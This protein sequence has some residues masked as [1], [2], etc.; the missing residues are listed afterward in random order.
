MNNNRRNAC[1]VRRWG[2]GFGLASAG[3]VAAAMMGVATAHA[4]DADELVSQAVSDLAHANQVLDQVPVTS[5]DPLQAAIFDEQETIQTG[6][7]ADLLNTA[8]TFQDGLPAADQTSPLLLDVDHQLVQAYSGLLDADQGFLTAD[9][10]GDLSGPGASV[11]L[12]DLS[13]IDANLVTL[14]ADFNVSA[15]DFFASF[16]PGILTA[17]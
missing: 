11:F 1:R 9:Q 7:A 16:D 6:P 14:G 12:P 17:F 4:D 2:T 10:A 8:Q 3:V 13:L 15:T 5:L